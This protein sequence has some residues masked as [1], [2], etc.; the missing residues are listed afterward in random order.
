MSM[1]AFFFALTWGILS[2]FFLLLVRIGARAVPAPPTRVSMRPCTV[3]FAGFL[4]PHLSRIEQIVELREHT[5]TLA[6]FLRT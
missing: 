3:R 1:G 4:S 2:L 5:V 6:G